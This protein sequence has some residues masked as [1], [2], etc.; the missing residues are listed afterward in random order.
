MD[1]L[2]AKI[3]N[4]R[5]QDM[6]FTDIAKQLGITKN[7]AIG[8]YWRAMQRGEQVRDSG[9]TGDKVTGNTRECV[10]AGPRI[11]T[12]EQFIEELEID[13]SEWVIERQEVRKWEVGAKCVEKDLKF[14]DGVINGYIKSTG[15]LSIEPLFY[16]RVVLVRR[17]PE[18]LHPHIKP[19]SL[20]VEQYPYRVKKCDVISS[21][22]TLFDAHIGFTRDWETGEL[23]PFHDV[24]AMKI[25]LQ[26]AKDKQPDVL[27]FG[28]DWLDL[29]EMSTKFLRPADMLRTT[30]DA[31]NEC[32][33]W[34]TWFREACPKAEMYYIEGNH[35]D[36]MRKLM[37]EH[38]I[39]IYELHRASDLAGHPL[40]SIPSL[41]DLD[42]LGIEYIE[43]Y[44]KNAL[45][46]EPF[47][48]VI[49][50]EVARAGSG[51]TA[52]VILAD[53]QES[54][55][56]GHGHKTEMLSK[57]VTDYSGQRYI[58][59]V[60]P[61]C[62]C[63]IDGIVPSSKGEMNWQQGIALSYTHDGCFFP[64]IIPINDGVAVYDGRVY[65][66]RE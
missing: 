5:N 29:A 33:K 54:V 61:G 22:M 46:V 64:T 4:L 62:L 7:K 27:V 9:V 56:Y 12:P 63:R 23:E 30:Q 6:K 48:K 41:L 10:W 59:A 34:L 28:G 51:D 20:N 55:I 35:D 52:R 43:G 44:P 40:I 31:I 57:T 8:R 26:I 25:A 60:S 50:G 24:R 37:I 58:Y 39:H 42:Q 16:V 19:V 17:N 32:A 66:G 2:T 36:R 65:D 13:L 11:V 21:I 15:Q 53:T 49:H 18:P 45:W 3:V 38:G 14:V 47:L 1:D